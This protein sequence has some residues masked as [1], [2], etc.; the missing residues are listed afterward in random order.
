M[1]E[2][3]DREAAAPAGTGP[4]AGLDAGWGMPLRDTR[5]HHPQNMPLSM[6][7]SHRPLRTSR[8][9]KSSKPRAHVFSLQRKFPFVEMAP[10]PQLWPVMKAPLNPQT[11]LTQQPLLAILLLLTYLPQ[12]ASPSK[13]PQTSPFSLSR[14]WSISPAL[15]GRGHMLHAR[16]PC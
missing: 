6:I 10:S 2:G 14:R 1:L 15:T 7:L 5:M 3:T 9:R 13:K 8:H 11:T 4:R 12:L 16:C